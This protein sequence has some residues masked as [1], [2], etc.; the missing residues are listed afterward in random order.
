[1]PDQKN[2]R[3]GL[4]LLIVKYINYLSVTVIKIPQKSNLQRKVYF[5]L[6]FPMAEMKWLQA[7]GV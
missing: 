7:A 3:K 4:S 6:C 5:G 1:M 2:L